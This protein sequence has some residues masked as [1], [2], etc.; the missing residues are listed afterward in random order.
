M[1]TRGKSADV[2]HQMHTITTPTVIV[3]G[4]VVELHQAV[5]IDTALLPLPQGQS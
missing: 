2:L 1:L 3:I 5:H 4:H